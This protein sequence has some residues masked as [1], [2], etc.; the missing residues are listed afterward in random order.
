MGEPGDRAAAY[1]PERRLGDGAA[2]HPCRADQ[3]GACRGQVE[4]SLQGDRLTPRLA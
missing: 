3:H 1:R 4:R 2:G